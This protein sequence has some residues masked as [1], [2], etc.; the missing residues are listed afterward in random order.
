MIP[1]R[2][3]PMERGRWVRCLRCTCYFARKRVPV[4]SETY[5]KAIS[6]ECRG[7]LRDGF[8]LEKCFVKSLR[9]LFI[10][11]TSSIGLVHRSDW[12]SSCISHL[13]VA[14]YVIHT[15]SRSHPLRPILPSSP[16][17]Q[18]AGSYTPYTHSAVT[19]YLD[20]LIPHHAH[21]RYR[22]PPIST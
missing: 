19:C 12:F 5:A 18:P 20:F 8:G 22:L 11:S 6:Y 9:H 7:A 3:E 21:I 4:V 17:V 14:S 10:A 2:Y 15:H 1:K 13:P 16:Y